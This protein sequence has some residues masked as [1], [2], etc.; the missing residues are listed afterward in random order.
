L[1]AF[2]DTSPVQWSILART[3]TG[4][5][6]KLQHVIARL[7][8]VCLLGISLVDIAPA[9]GANVLSPA[10]PVSLVLT[11]QPIIVCD[12]AGLNCAPNSGLAAYET[13]ANT[14]FDQ[15]GIGVAFAPPRF[16]DN[17]NFLTPH[18]DTTT[19]GLFDTAHDL[20]RLP[21]HGQSTNPNTLNVFLVDN[22]VSTTNGVVNTNVHSYGYGLIGGNGSIIATA[23][24]S[25]GK[26]AAT[27]TM[28][29]E[30]A[31][32]L[33]LAHSDSPVQPYNSNYNLMNTASR[34][35]AT[36][37]CQITP[38]TCAGAPATA[39][40]V[41][42][43]PQLATLAAPPILTALPNVRDTNV[44]V[45]P[46]LSLPPGQVAEQ[47]YNYIAPAPTLLGV[48]WRFTNP[49]TVPDSCF[50]FPVPAGGCGYAGLTSNAIG[51]GQHV[52]WVYNIAGLGLAPAVPFSVTF[53]CASGA[54]STEFDFSNG[55]TSRAGFDSTGLALSQNG[56]VF[57]FDPTAPGVLTGPSFLP[58]DIGAISPLTGLPIAPET[59]TASVT[60]DVLAA[61]LGP[62]A[63]LDG[64]ASV[65]E[66]A[67]AA[68]LA[69]GIGFMALVRR[70]RVRRGRPGGKARFHTEVTEV[71]SH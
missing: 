40:D 1:R 60:P 9:H 57:T 15:S 47:Q 71:Q 4:G 63:T 46:T 18:V 21:G 44:D 62:F 37:P 54:Y 65:P 69:M 36:D 30:L 5:V 59:D 29:H 10:V 61:I 68:S 16:Y 58:M 11:V 2:V 70:R 26:V 23:P 20:L 45:G 8:P 52:E 48:K 49:A 39:R 56:A 19:S 22:I 31:H 35:V 34:V 53:C 7:M 42:A 43:A 50:S 67:G 64:T 28:A 55:I 38:Y 32:N 51:G 33:G 14:I 3:A 25:L 13:M 17:T 6:V 27:D 12:N 24:D 66:P 41:L